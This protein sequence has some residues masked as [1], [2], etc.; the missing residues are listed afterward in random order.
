MFFV[1]ATTNMFYKIFFEYTGI[2]GLSIY[3]CCKIKE[4]LFLEQDI[5][6]MIKSYNIAIFL[7]SLGGFLLNSG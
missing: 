6:I 7:I 1:L 2:V 3:F 5:I 4:R